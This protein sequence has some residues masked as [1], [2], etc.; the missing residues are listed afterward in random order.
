M[1]KVSNIYFLPILSEK[2]IRGYAPSKLG[3]KP[4]K[5]KARDTE[6]RDPTQGKAKE[7]PG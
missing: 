3:D 7:I 4:R 2:D 6:T 1:C 5:R